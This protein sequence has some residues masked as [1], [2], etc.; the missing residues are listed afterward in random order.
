MPKEEGQ[1]ISGN[2]EDGRSDIATSSSPFLTHLDAI[3]IDLIVE[4]T[5]IKKEHKTNKKNDLLPY[6]H[7][8]VVEHQL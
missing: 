2:S 8:S 5:L 6:C 7:G 3:P 1:R 4:M